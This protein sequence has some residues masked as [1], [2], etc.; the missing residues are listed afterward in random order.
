MEEKRGGQVEKAME[1][2][3]NG[4]RKGENEKKRKGR[5]RGK[6]KDGKSEGGLKKRTM[7][8]KQASSLLGSVGRALS[9]GGDG[10]ARDAQKGEF[11]DLISAL[12]TG[13]VFSDDKIKR[14]RKGGKAPRR[15]DSR[16]RHK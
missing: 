13:D 12:R 8:R 2:G 6:K 5:E 1:R 7:E 4:K 11:D 9:R 15:E 14:A 10:A 3:R 16:E